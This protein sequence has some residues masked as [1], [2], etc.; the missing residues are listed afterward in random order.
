[1][2]NPS[3]IAV[4]NSLPF[5]TLQKNSGPSFLPCFS[6]LP[7]IE[8]DII[9]KM[10]LQAPYTQDRLPP[11]SVKEQLVDFARFQWPLLFSRFFEVTK[12]SGNGKTYGMGEGTEEGI[13]EAFL[14]CLQGPA[15]P[16]TI[17]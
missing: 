9:F 12:F 14:L 10:F 16:R 3:C 4:N 7:L 13:P 8:L 17:S 11:Q 6:I 5:H 15:C 2:L 1:M